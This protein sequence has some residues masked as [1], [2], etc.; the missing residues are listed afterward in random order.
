MTKW[1]VAAALSKCF[2]QQALGV[3]SSQGCVKLRSS[4]NK[5]S[6]SQNQQ[7]HMSPSKGEVRTNLKLIGRNG[8]SRSS[9]FQH[10]AKL[11]AF[12]PCV[13]AHAHRSMANCSAAQEVDPDRH[14]H[15]SFL[16]PT[17]SVTRPAMPSKP[18]KRFSV[19]SMEAQGSVRKQARVDGNSALVA[20][21]RPW[22]SAFWAFEGIGA[23]WAFRGDIYQE[24]FT[25][26]MYIF[27]KCIYLNIFPYSLK[28]YQDIYTCFS[29][30]Q[31]NRVLD[32]TR[33]V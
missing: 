29:Q 6:V 33:L 27:S 10:A 1:L 19:A 12:M 31:K 4:A 8:L 20:A 23:A 5:R 25:V 9:I 14:H 21:I 26:Y 3:Q 28:I 2:T 32:N 18:S 30:K 7:F 11:V 16:R 17:S 24:K 22:G 15:S 13:S